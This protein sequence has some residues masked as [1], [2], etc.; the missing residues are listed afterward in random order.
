MKAVDQ[1]PWFW[2]GSSEEQCSDNPLCINHILRVYESLARDA[3]YCE[4]EDQSAAIILRDQM[5]EYLQ[6]QLVANMMMQMPNNPYWENFC[7]G[8]P[9]RS[10]DPPAAPSS[11][12]LK[13]TQCPK[14]LMNI[15][16]LRRHLRFVHTD[17]I[18]QCHQCSKAIKCSRALAKH[19]VF[20]GQTRECDKC[21]QHI[22]LNVWL[23]H[24]KKCAQPH[25]HPFSS[26]AFPNQTSENR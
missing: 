25:H 1:Y 21:C 12:R 14:T 3:M 6:A 7:T 5:M 26:A 19:Q 23:Q 4:P 11:I 20:C 22:P 24:Q 17:K 10:T 9:I 2:C 15:G 18:S 16:S 8:T 13:C